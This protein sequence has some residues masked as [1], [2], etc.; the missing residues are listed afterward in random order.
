M[1]ADAR[2]P[3]MRTR[4]TE[5]LGIRYPIIQGGMQWVGRAELAAAISNA[6]GLGTLTGLT[7][8]TPE[9]FA[10]EIER[11]RAMTDQPFA[12]NLTVFPKIKALPY[13]AYVDAII[14]SRVKIVDRGQPRRLLLAE[15]EGCGHQDHP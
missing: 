2:E 4:V 10:T 15:N 3:E 9:A 14:A 1:M 5:L 13:E 8:P 6:G 11:C 7:Q 12:V